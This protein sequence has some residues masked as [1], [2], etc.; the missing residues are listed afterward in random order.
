MHKKLLITNLVFNSLTWISI[1]FAALSL[2][3]TSVAYDICLGVFGL[4]PYV[5][6]L[7]IGIIIIIHSQR[8]VLPTKINLISG[9]ATTCLSGIMILGTIICHACGNGAQVFTI[10]MDCLSFILLAW[11]ILVYINLKQNDWFLA[12]VHQS[13]SIFD[14]IF[15]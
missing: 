10:V 13:K 7:S 4:L 12:K 6:M 1:I 3:H 9:I 15:W 2:N 11:N 5:V 8:Y 14:L